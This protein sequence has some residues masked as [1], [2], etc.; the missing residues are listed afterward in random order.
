MTDRQ[1]ERRADWDL[2]LFVD[3]GTPLDSYTILVARHKRCLCIA[4]AHC[5]RDK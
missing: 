5:V 2:L 4:E 1:T 3:G